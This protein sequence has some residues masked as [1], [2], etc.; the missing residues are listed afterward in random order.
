MAECVMMVTYLSN[1]LSTKSTI[2]SPFELL[3]GVKP[4][5]PEILKVF[6]EVGVITTKDKIQAKLTNQ[7]TT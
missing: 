2:N 3:Y 4:T 7:G 6:G 1:V 5:P